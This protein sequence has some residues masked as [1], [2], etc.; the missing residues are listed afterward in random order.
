MVITMYDNEYKVRECVCVC[1]VLGFGMSFRWFKWRE[2][3]LVLFIVTKME[4][5][6]HPNRCRINETDSKKLSVLK[7]SAWRHN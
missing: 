4:L 2:L 5:A 1:V 6:L 3:R 7:S